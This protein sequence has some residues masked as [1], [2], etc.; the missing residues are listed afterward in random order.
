MQLINKNIA[1]AIQGTSITDRCRYSRCS[2]MN[3]KS[4]KIFV[5]HY[6]PLLHF[7]VYLNTYSI[8]ASSLLD[9]YNGR[10]S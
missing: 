8:L 2:G 9:E 6:I 7:F 5:N 1:S 4:K 10:Y 3:A